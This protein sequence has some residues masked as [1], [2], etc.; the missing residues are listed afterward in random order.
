MFQRDS[1]Q[2]SNENLRLPDCEVIVIIVE[3]SAND[4]SILVTERT[5]LQ[6]IQV[7]PFNISYL[8][9]LG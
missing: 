2:S 8:C 6:W 5:I 3:S 9:C 4:Q 1:N 7:V